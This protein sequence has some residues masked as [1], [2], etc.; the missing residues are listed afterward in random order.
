MRNVVSVRK[1]AQYKEIVLVM[2]DWK[3]SAFPVLD[4]HDKVVAVGFMTVRMS[5]SGRRFPCR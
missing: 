2:R 4:E 5:S 1:H 3:F